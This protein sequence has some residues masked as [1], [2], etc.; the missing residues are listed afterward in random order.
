[1]LVAL[2]WATGEPKTQ[3]T[4]SANSPTSNES[5]PT[6]ESSP[7]LFSTPNESNSGWSSALSESDNN[8]L[9]PK[10]QLEEEPN[11]SDSEYCWTTEE[12]VEFFSSQK[13]IIVN[14]WVAGLGIFVPVYTD[15][16]RESYRQ[17]HPYEGYS[18]DTLD[19]L[20]EQSDALAL[21]TLGLMA[22]YRAFHQAL[23]SESI[24]LFDNAAFEIEA[25]EMVNM[26]AFDESQDLLFRAAASGRVE[27]LSEI[28]F[29]YFYFEL[30]AKMN[31]R[32]EAQ[33]AAYH[34]QKLAFD[35]LRTRILPSLPR[36]FDGQL[37]TPESVTKIT[38]ALEAEYDD[39][40]LAENKERPRPPAEFLEYM[41]FHNNPRC[42]D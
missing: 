9:E 15:E 10:N 2:L 6:R 19:A 31:G 26:D 27:A 37:E 8:S 21:H 33:I 13:M 7:S 11:K 30:W 38:D 18:E 16:T 5:R 25:N 12:K 29:N 39:L 17:Q 23:P 35:R 4:K 22:R 36:H 24:K 3:Q 40:L 42:N 14:E 32:S 20:A 1:M 41:E 34:E 28:A